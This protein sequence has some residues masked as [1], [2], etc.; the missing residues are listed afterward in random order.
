MTDGPSLL[1]PNAQLEYTDAD[2]RAGRVNIEVSSGHYRDQSILAKS[3]AGF[4][5]HAT[6]AARM[7]VLK[8]LGSG[9]GEGNDGTKGPSQRGPAAFEL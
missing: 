2:G 1:D 6:G 8:A 5:L 9:R 3:N 7:H 4:V